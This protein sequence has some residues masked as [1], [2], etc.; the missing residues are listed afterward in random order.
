M[1]KYIKYILLFI[2]LN[3]TFACTN[4]R[5][6]INKTVIFTPEI[7][8]IGMLPDWRADEIE[9][10]MINWINKGYK[11]L[12]CIDSAEYHKFRLDKWK[13]YME[14]L[15]PK[16]NFFFV[17]Q[18]S[19]FHLMKAY[20][21]VVDIQ[22][23]HLIKHPMYVDEFGDFYRLNHLSDNPAFRCFLLD[24]D[25]KILAIGNPVDNSKIRKLYNKIINGEE[26]DL[27]PLTAVEFEPREIELKNLQVGKTSDTVFTLKNVG[28]H[29]LTILR[30]DTSCCCNFL[31][32]DQTQ[33]LLS[34]T[35]GGCTVQEWEKRPIESGKTTEIKVQI[36]PKEAGSFWKIIPVW[37]NTKENL[38]FLKIKGTVKE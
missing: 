2:L 30:V 5:E 23:K 6:W 25:N 4:K 24:N 36:T 8:G 16:V 3:A 11:I 27:L 34:E 31:S 32:K 38:F 1:K 29:P 13:I 14:E 22:K 21:F 15:Y 19:R 17:F 33:H 10:T 35:L 26:S 28:T 18:S 37:C 20:T 9:Q 7:G 12:V